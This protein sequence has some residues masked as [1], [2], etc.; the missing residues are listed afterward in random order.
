MKAT[1]HISSEVLDNL[2]DTVPAGPLPAELTND[3]LAVGGA[4][5]FGFAV[6]LTLIVLLFR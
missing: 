3:S 2:G 4:W 5:L 6:A 1:R